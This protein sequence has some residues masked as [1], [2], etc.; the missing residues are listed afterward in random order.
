MLF[1]SL[2]KYLYIIAWNLCLLIHIFIAK[3]A[4]FKLI[5]GPNIQIRNIYPNRSEKSAVEFTLGYI[6]LLNY[7]INRCLPSA[8]QGRGNDRSPAISSSRDPPAI[9]RRKSLKLYCLYTPVNHHNLSLPLICHRWMHPYPW[10][11]PNS[12]LKKKFPAFTPRGEKVNCA[13]MAPPK[14]LPLFHIFFKVRC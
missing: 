2:F 7:F 13:Y 9:Y 6:R 3:N 4:S 8:K 11:W 14:K 10:T 1:K 12:N 5:H